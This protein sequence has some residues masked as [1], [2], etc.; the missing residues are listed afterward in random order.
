V[1]LGPL[2]GDDFA[3]L[4]WLFGAI[5]VDRGKSAVVMGTSVGPEAGDQDGP[6][7]RNVDEVGAQG[8]GPVEER[9]VPFTEVGQTRGQAAPWQGA[10]L[11]TPERH[12]SRC[13]SHKVRPDPL[14]F[15]KKFP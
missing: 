15:G 8:V 7:F 13:A 2:G 10:H 6:V 9:A 1:V 11:E 12:E 4:G 14:A 3:M 5:V